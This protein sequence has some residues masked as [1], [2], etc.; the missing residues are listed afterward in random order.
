MKPGR[1]MAAEV[2]E[3]RPAVFAVCDCIACAT[4][5]ACDI[6]GERW[7]EEP[8]DWRGTSFGHHCK[9][10]DEGP[11]PAQQAKIAAIRATLEGR[12]RDGGQLMAPV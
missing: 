9:F 7:G 12:P 4:G 11:T 3:I 8:V 2:A 6:V 5:I 10:A 1:L